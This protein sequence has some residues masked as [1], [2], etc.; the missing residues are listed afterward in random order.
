MSIASFGKTRPF[1]AATQASSGRGWSRVTAFAAGIAILAGSAGTY[2]SA[3][4]GALAPTHASFIQSS[5]WPAEAFG[6]GGFFGYEFENGFKTEIE[7]RNAHTDATRSGNLLS[8]GGLATN[9]L[10]LN[11]IYEFSDGSWRL[12][13]YVGAGLGTIDVSEQLLGTGAYNRITAYQLRGGVTLGMT[14]KLLGSLEYRWTNGS[15]PYLSLAG[16][17]AKFEVDRHG[18]LAGVN[19]RF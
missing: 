1:P 17:P 8:T 16:I 14:Q 9:R 3:D 2:V 19:Y 18:F 11:G 12:K 6:T 15:K 5:L 10:M 4:R 7:G 13:P